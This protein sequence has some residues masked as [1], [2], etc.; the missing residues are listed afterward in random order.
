MFP[1]S[2]SETALRQLHT[3]ENV[4]GLVA[5]LIARAGAKD[6]LNWWDDDS[7]TSAGEFVLGRIFPRKW[8]LIS[9]RLAI[10]AAKEKH[11]GAARTVGLEDIATLF[12]NVSTV[13]LESTV[14]EG[15]VTS[16]LHSMDE[17]RG[18]LATL[19]PRVTEFDVPQPQ[20]SGLLDITDIT[21]GD[22]PSTETLVAAFAS[23][24][25]RAQAG[26][27]VFPFIRR[28]GGVRR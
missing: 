12:S 17:F 23:G 9:C 16:P 18:R 5:L 13:G 10:R 14:A 4:S 7:L 6:S 11:E 22:N 8:K 21:G 20:D 3:E 24:Y 28:F 15:I 25:T 19:C 2:N 27:P 26:K 1:N